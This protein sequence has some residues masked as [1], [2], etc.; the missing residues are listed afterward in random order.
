MRASTCMLLAA[1]VFAAAS[2]A[3]TEAFVTS[4]ALPAAT[5]RS[6]AAE[7]CRSLPLKVAPPPA[8][9]GMPGC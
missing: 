5:V 8:P 3:S 7:I 9:S 1:A 2:L 6:A 4:G